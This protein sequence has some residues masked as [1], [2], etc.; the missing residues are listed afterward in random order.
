MFDMQAADGG[1]DKELTRGI[2]RMPLS[3][4]IRPMGY[5]VCANTTY[6]GIFDMLLVT[7]L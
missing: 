2:L 7:N 6:Q 4:P 5:H 1:F 3:V